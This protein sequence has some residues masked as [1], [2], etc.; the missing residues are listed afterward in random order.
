MYKISPSE[1]QK[2]LKLNSL[3]NIK[4]LCIVFFIKSFIYL[5]KK[6]A[7]IQKCNFVEMNYSE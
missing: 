1:I 5:E 6:G 4:L 2:S 7:V 3:A